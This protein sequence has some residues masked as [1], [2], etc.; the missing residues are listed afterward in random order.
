MSDAF[1][2]SPWPLRFELTD[3]GMFKTERTLAEEARQ[4]I[5]ELNGDPDV[6]ALF[7]LP[8]D[9]D[10]TVDRRARV[11]TARCKWQYK[12]ALRCPRS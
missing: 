8:D 3:D 4:R 1:F 6:K 5:T 11:V 10:V 12:E 9:R 2:E 7:L